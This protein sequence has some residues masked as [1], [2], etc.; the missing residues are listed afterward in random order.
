MVC[1]NTIYVLSISGVVSRFPE[2]TKLVSE[3]KKNIVKNLYKTELKKAVAIY[4]L[5]CV[6]MILVLES[7]L[8]ESIVSRFM[9]I[10]QIVCI[11]IG[12]LFYLLASVR[13]YYMRAHLVDQTLSL[14]LLAVFLMVISTFLGIFLYGIWGISIS[15]LIIFSCFLFPWMLKLTRDL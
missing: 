4:S 13:G 14:Y 15:I 10:G 6:S 5:L 2:L 7:F 9:S 11:A 1:M 3:N 8:A 12:M